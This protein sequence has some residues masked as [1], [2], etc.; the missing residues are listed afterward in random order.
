MTRRRTLL[1]CC[2]VL[3]AVSVLAQEQTAQADAISG[4]WGSDSQTLL[5]LKFDGE[6]AVTGTAYFYLDD[7]Q[8]KYSSTVTT[9]TF[10]PKR[11]ALKLEGEF[12]GPNDAIVPYLIV[13]QLD[14][15]ALQV[16]YVIGDNKGSMTMKKMQ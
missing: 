6:G 3:S 1:A 14:K 12:K 11:G 8:R 7:G 9:G 13:G 10:N 15:E 2:I 4:K 5:D 16:K